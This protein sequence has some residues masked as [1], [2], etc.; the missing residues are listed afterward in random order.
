MDE[1][2][3]LRSDAELRC[4]CGSLMARVTMRGIELKCRRC[5]RLV[6]V[7]ADQMRRGWVHVSLHAREVVHR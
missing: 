5:K 6:V 4:D 7:T 1:P 3:S 2:S